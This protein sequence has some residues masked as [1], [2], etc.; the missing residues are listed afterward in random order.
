MFFV[1]EL[2]VFKYCHLDANN[3]HQLCKLCLNW[4]KWHFMTQDE[5]LIL[6][7]LREILCLILHV[8]CCS[9]VVLESIYL[10]LLKLTRLPYKAIGN[11]ES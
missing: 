8:L 5:T 1:F 7:N 2:N 9:Y 3:E 4:L 6:H 11:S 10:M